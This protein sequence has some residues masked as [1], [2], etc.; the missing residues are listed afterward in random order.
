LQAARE[1]AGEKASLLPLGE[2]RRAAGGLR[3]RNAPEVAVIWA[4]GAINT[5][6]SR[7]LPLRG[8]SLGSD[9]L[10]LAL[11]Q[12][13]DD[14]RVRAVVLR[15]NSPGGSYVASDAIWRE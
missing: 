9:T 7:R 14:R 8:E 13:R 2:Y 3:H 10:T 15:I 5:G 12:A 11:R 6:R 1:R 4:T